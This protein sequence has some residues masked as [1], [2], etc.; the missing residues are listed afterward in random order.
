MEFRFRFSSRFI[1]IPFFIVLI[2]V[3][4][5]LSRIE[6]QEEASNSIPDAPV[7]AI[8]GMH[9]VMKGYSAAPPVIRHRWLNLNNLSIATLV[10]GEALDSWSTHNN[11]THPK[12]ICG[13][14]PDFGNTL[15]YISPN[16]GLN[17]GP[18]SQN[19]VCGPGPSGQVANYAYDATQ[20]GAYT[21]TGWVTKFHLAGNR[22]YA[23]VEAWNLANDV[24]QFL[25]ARYASKRLAR[26]RKVGPALN[27]SHGFGHIECGV[28]NIRFAM[29]HRNANTWEFPA[30]VDS[31]LVPGP[32]WWGAQ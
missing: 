25:I 26:L 31:S 12:W 32:R 9:G 16:P 23:G 13:Y 24:G 17:E 8:P 1:S 7:P 29:Q 6:A 21:E 15:I 20:M 22:N 11:L 14:N 4:G 30:T 18:S 27:F 10:A 28:L 5:V 2:F 3:V 19:T